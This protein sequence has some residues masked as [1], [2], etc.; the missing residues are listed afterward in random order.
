MT[1]IVGILCRDGVVVAA[2]SAATYGALGQPTI[3]QPTKKIDIVDGSVIIACSGAIGLAQRFGNE[4]TQLWRSSAFAGGNAVTAG[5]KIGE[6]LKA[7]IAPE[8]NVA[9][10]ARNVVG[11]SAVQ[12]ATCLSIVAM[13]LTK[14][15]SLIQFSE[16]GSPEVATVDLPF[17]S[18][19]VGQ[20]TAD[21]FLAFLRALFW[22]SPK[23][24]PLLADGIFAALWTLKHAIAHTPGGIAAPI[25]I[26]VLEP[27]SSKWVARMLSNEERQEHEQNI[28]G[29][30]EAL[31]R[32]KEFGAGEKPVPPP[33]KPDRNS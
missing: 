3:S 30:E 32:Y 24:P 15:P 22:P 14:N 21:P 20:T 6:R 11:T 25:D 26:A 8:M 9:Q 28:A 5:V 10:F 4:I 18:I 1:L 27:Q 29:A 16:I 33:P 31:R 7:H 2:D 17:V 23:Q 19:G 13:P 12:Q